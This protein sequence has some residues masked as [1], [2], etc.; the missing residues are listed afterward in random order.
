MD[1]WARLTQLPEINASTR[2]ENDAAQ[3]VVVHI[4]DPM[5]P[6]VVMTY[7]HRKQFG[8]ASCGKVV[9]LKVEN[10]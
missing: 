7:Y 1:S 4:H 8:E 2:N 10:L 3:K 5:I 6:N 9:A